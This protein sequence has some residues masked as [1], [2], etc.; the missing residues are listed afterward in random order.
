VEPHDFLE[1]TGEQPERIGVPQ[2]GLGGEG[3]PRDILEAAHV[4]RREA[5]LREA[6]AEQRHAVM[7]A[8]DDEPQPGQLQFAQLRRRQE[9]HRA[10]RMKAAVEL[11][12]EAH[13]NVSGRAARHAALRGL[14]PGPLAALCKAAHGSGSVSG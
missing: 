6:L 11:G 8:T 5:A 1:R 3:Q 9:I 12:I 7:R 2:I 14:A 10:G 13:V 4:V